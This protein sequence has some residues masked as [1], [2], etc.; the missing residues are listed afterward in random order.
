M[1]GK[2]DVEETRASLNT[3]AKQEDDLEELAFKICE[4][5]QF[6]KHYVGRIQYNVYPGISGHELWE[7]MKKNQSWKNDD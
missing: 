1:A 7:W 6:Q 3:N 2:D 4:D 5:A